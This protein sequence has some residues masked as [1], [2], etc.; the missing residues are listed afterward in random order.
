MGGILP[1]KSILLA[2]CVNN[3]KLRAVLIQVAWWWLALKTVPLCLPGPMVIGT[4]YRRAL[5]QI[6]AERTFG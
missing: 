1:R 3:V 5:A 4:T 6:S 2:P